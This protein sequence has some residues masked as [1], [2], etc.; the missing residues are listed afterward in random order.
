MRLCRNCLYSHVRTAVSKMAVF[1]RNIRDEDHCWLE[2]AIPRWS[3]ESSENPSQT[4][5]TGP[6]A[7]S[8]PSHTWPACTIGVRHLE[9]RCNSAPA[10]LSTCPE[11]SQSASSELPTSRQS[12]KGTNSTRQWHVRRELALEY[13]GRN[14]GRFAYVFLLLVST[15]Y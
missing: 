13:G 8:K 14:G 11:S 12:S 10:V 9:L 6:K 15:S 7:L 1:P 3:E 2:A 5:G 4:A